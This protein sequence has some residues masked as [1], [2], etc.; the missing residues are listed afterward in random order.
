M[1]VNII[2][3]D[4]TDGYLSSAQGNYTNSRNGINLAATTA[5]G[6]VYYGESWDSPNYFHHQ[7]FMRWS[8]VATPGEVVT[9]AVMRVRHAVINASDIPRW[10]EFRR[11]DWGASVDVAD[12]R[13]AAALS[14]LDWYA[15]VWDAHTAIGKH[16]YAGSTQLVGKLNADGTQTLGMVLVSGRQRQGNIPTKDETS[17]VWAA[18]TAGTAD[19]P[20]LIYTTVPRST[21]V[22]MGAAQA[23][24]SD[25][26]WVYLE[27]NGV[28]PSPTVTLKRNDGTASATLAA[29]PIGTSGSD[30]GGTDGVG[31]QSMALVVDAAD[32]IYVIG[33]VGNAGNSLA[34]KAYAKGGGLVWTGQPLRSAGLP[35]YAGA[36]NNVA[37]AFHQT[38]AGPRVI[39]AAV[40]HTAHDAFPGGVGNELVYAI[41]S[42]D[43]LITGA[44]SLLRASGSAL[45]TIQPAVT[46]SGEF[47]TLANETGSG[48]DLIPGSATH[49]YVLSFA[50]GQVLGDNHPLQVGRYALAADG[51]SLAGSE[52]ADLGSWGVK[53]ATGK[54]RVVCIG[55]GVIATVT[56]DE[57]AGFGPAVR[58]LQNTAPGSWVTLGRVD[59]GGEAVPSLPAEAAMART[60]AWDAIYNATEHTLWI[61]YAD[62]ANPRQVRR[63][64]VD[65]S[66]YQATRAETLVG[67]PIGADGTV[68]AIRVARN[69]RATRSTLVT[70]AHKSA[71]GAL[72]T[73]Y[74][75]DIFNVAPTEPTLAPK[76]NYDATAASTFSWAFSDPNVGDAQSAYQLQVI[77]TDTGATTLDTGKVASA[78]TSH[79]LAGGTLT[80]GLAYQWRVRTYDA[81]DVVSPW[82]PYGTFSTSAGGTVTITDP[83]TDNPAG[84][85][86]DNYVVQWAVAGT[87]QADRRVRVVRSDTGAQLLDTGYVASPDN[88]YEVTGMLTDV[89]YQVQVTVR[90]ASAVP[91]GTGARLITP[92]YGTPE[93]PAVT[94]DAYGL[95]GYIR[96]GITNPPPQGD[97][98]NVIRNDIL[99]RRAGSADPYLTVGTCDPGQEFR[100]YTA[101]SGVAYEYVVRGVA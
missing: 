82:S 15:T 70:V 35:S 65:L 26:S 87:V 86:T 31:S 21:L 8:Y 53:D 94:V 71:A 88:F 98:P 48:L 67:G 73:T 75:V 84:V 6:T 63:T 51:S 54:V 76:A 96:V 66:T 69:E 50:K 91:S 78:V 20:A 93:V 80:N 47:N 32:N 5:S 92:S 95:D 39:F 58:V 11:Y 55:T 12:W 13:N 3:G 59:F 9:S 24:L 64:S 62:A 18:D 27:S 100:D 4:A 40:G 34:A 89:E 45:G 44:G 14:A 72:T 99:R 25:G 46:A 79:A 23:R 29:V 2:Y 90:N 74:L 85:I 43:H 19:D 41:L 83:A 57:D 16:S 61:Y 1:T 10:L 81:L 17:A 36:I 22:R 30:F 52:Y 97:R 60:L 68:Q 37:A 28:E 101:A 56:M 42:A 7:G 38:P 49:G 77:R 33:R